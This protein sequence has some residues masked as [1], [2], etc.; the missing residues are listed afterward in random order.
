MPHFAEG[1]VSSFEVEESDEPAGEEPE[2]DATITV[3]EGSVEAETELPAGTS[4][5]EFV[6][7]GEERHELTAVEKLDEDATFEDL[8]EHFDSFDEGL[9]PTADDL[10]D[11]PGIL[12]L[13]VFDVPGGDR[14][15][16]DLELTEGTWVL[17]CAMEDEETGEE[18]GE[19]ETV[20]VTVT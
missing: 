16:V 10:E 15:Y 7:D 3:S 14:Y 4:T 9:P 12:D 13:F 5:I 18:H 17:G 2:A 1:M 19:N 20:E 6:N 11:G 8:D